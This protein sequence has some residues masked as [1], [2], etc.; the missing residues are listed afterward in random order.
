MLDPLQRL[1]LREKPALALLAVEEM[2]IA[3][4]ALI[5]KRIDSTFPHTSGI[6]SELE[7]QGL[8]KSRPDGRVRYLELTSRGKEVA[9]SLKELSSLL[10]MPERTML[11]LERLQQMAS[12]A[13]GPD[14]S[15]CL[16][17]LRRDLAKLKG[18]EDARLRQAAE[19]FDAAIVAALHE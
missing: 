4:A 6:L 19:D 15:F 12:K 8:I 17:P 7:K 3:Y 10:K 14:K 16:G 11:R 9:R 18:Q 2:E 13:T 1:F 5:A